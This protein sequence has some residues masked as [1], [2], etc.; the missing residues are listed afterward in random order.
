MM[1]IINMKD[2]IINTHAEKMI[3]ISIIN[4]QQRG[5]SVSLVGVFRNFAE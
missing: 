5:L 3:N 2:I 4:T 1:I